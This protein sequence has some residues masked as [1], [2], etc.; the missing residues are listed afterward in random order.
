MIDA[1]LRGEIRHL[2][3]LPFKR[4][5]FYADLVLLTTR[6][7]IRIVGEGFDLPSGEEVFFLNLVEYEPDTYWVDKLGRPAW[8]PRPDE[9]GGGWSAVDLVAKWRRSALPGIA[10]ADRTVRFFRDRRAFS[11]GLTSK[12]ALQSA[13]AIT[14]SE[15]SE[16][17]GQ[18]IIYATAEF[19]CSL[20]ITAE[21]KRIDS[22]LAGLQEFRLS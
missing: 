21:V 22:I 11:E 19:P 18:L 6:G 14:L 1:L 17:A 7:D 10:G 20:E 15:T 12:G 8:P 13:S 9:L 3:A 2:P 4:K 5:D 16:S